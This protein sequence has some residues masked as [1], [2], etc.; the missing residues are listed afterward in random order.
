MK[1][2]IIGAGN[3]AVQMAN[4]LNEM[5]TASAYA[6][7][8]RSLEKAEAFAK[9]HQV[10]KAYG[11]YEA[12]LAD[13]EVDLVYIATPHSHHYQHGMLALEHGKPILVEKAF[14][15]NFQEAKELID[16]SHQKH[17]F[18][19]E[20]IWTRYMPS[21]FMIQEL[22]R[23]GAIGNVFSCTANLGYKINHVPRLIDPKLAG[24][25]LL[26]LGVYPINFALMV[27]EGAIKEVTST[28]VMTDSGVDAMNSMTLTFEDGKIAVLH[29]TM[30]S[31]TDRKGVIYGDQGTLVIDNINNCDVI[32][33]YDLEWNE[34][35]KLHVPTKITG[36]EYQVEACRKAIEAGLIEVAE[37][38]HK[39]ILRVM[40]LMDQMSEEWK[41]K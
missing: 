31:N 5:T 18:V 17:V 33:Q 14:T 15:A 25:A 9:A 32:T 22:I 1:V 16:M 11:S 13:D 23:E 10:E 36:F 29:S 26:D 41:K 37:M 38:P 2:G 12:L 3:I 35:S 39:E 28:A 21:R 34:V 6:V 8:S 40:D 20:A 4:T 30:M 27:L 7:G 19:A 24:G